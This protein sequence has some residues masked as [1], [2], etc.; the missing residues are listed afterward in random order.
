M[1]LARNLSPIKITI[2][3]F[4]WAMLMSFILGVFGISFAGVFGW[5]IIPPII[6]GQ[7]YTK[8]YQVVMPANLR[9]YSA[10]YYMS[11]SCLFGLFIIIPLLFILQAEKPIDNFGAAIASVF[12]FFCV[13][14]VLGALSVYSFLRA[15]PSEKKSN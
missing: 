1:N 8:K 5:I 6:V 11:L 2:L 10:I 9:K 15:E 3:L 4:A 12:L 14:F 13:Y 7:Y